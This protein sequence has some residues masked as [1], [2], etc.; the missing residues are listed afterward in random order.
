MITSEKMTAALLAAGFQP[1]TVKLCD[2]AYSLPDAKYIASLAD[3]F[4]QFLWD[5]RLTYK[6]NR[7][8]CD[9][10]AESCRFMAMTDHE[11]F[12]LAP[13]GLAFGLCTVILPPLDFH[14]INFAVLQEGDVVKVRFYEPQPSPLCLQEKFLGSDFSS[15]LWGLV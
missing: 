5:N 1:N 4:G 13:T 6:P 3:R 2:D 11:R 9:K 12:S 8:D 14:C 7:F 10:F 15:L